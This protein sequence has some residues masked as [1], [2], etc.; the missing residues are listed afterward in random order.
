MEANNKVHVGVRVNRTK[1]PKIC[2]VK[3]STVRNLLKYVRLAVYSKHKQYAVVEVVSKDYRNDNEVVNEKEL[4]KGIQDVAIK[5]N[6]KD[7]YIGKDDRVFIFLDIHKFIEIGNEILGD[8]NV[9]IMEEL[10]QIRKK[11]DRVVIMS[12]YHVNKDEHVGQKKLF[13]I[14]Y[15]KFYWRN[16][17]RD[18]NDFVRNCEHCKNRN[19]E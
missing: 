14:I 17:S 6:L 18:I 4:I 9:Y 12:K 3:V 1:I 5:T 7:F 8:V 15:D 16:M 11:E 2:T 19:K 10:I 13:A